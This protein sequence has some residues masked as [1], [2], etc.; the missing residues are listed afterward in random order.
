MSKDYSKGMTVQ[1]MIGVLTRLP[2]DA[3]FVGA[4]S[5]LDEVKDQPGYFSH[6]VELTLRYPPKPMPAVDVTDRYTLTD[7]GRAALGKK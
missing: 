6:R 7:A 2:S 4:T 1:E 5:Y 3:R